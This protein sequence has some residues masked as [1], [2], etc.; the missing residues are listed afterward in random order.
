MNLFC[1][2]TDYST[3][4]VTQREKLAY[5]GEQLPAALNAIAAV[6][7]KPEMVILSTCNR[8]E[9]YI[10]T[11]QDPAN[12]ATRLKTFL[13]ESRKLDFDLNQMLYFHQ[14]PECVT[15]L[16]AV[17]SGLKS[18]V[19]GETEILGQTKDA[20]QKASLGGFTGKY[21]NKLFQF[22]FSAAKEAR[23]H[24]GIGRGSV[25]VASV[26]VDLSEQIFGSLKEVRAMV[27]GAGETGERVARTLADKG[28]MKVM[29]S[30][31]THERALEL[32]KSLGGEAI[33]WEEWEMHL[34]EADVVIA[35][36]SAPHFILH[37][38]QLEELMPRRSFRPIFLIDLA[39][40]RDIEPTAS[41]LDSVYLYDVD[42]LQSIASQHLSE[43]QQEIEN[44]RTLL[45]V[46]EQRYSDWYERALLHGKTGAGGQ[47]SSVP[48][49]G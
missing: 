44:C 7:G 42:D 17:A 41:V 1:L 5:T 46:H 36:T 24:S 6:L 13:R 18:M 32:S 16:F 45:K 39:I 8:T 2:G 25:S 22:S 47:E 9:F 31:R 10:A 14:G 49:A 11:E 35:S 23:T 33:R 26:A 34:T 27:L 20:Y 30:N 21:L 48:E 40:P 28:V 43:R 37:R 3:S 4:E 38:K 19:V 12:A 29:V 15:H